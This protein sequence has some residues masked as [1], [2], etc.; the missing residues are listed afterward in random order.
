MSLRELAPVLTE[1][2]RDVGVDRRL[3][4]QCAQ[5]VKL[6]RRVRDVVVAAD[7]MRDSI[8]PVVE[9][10]S[11]VVRRAAVRA[12]QNEILELLV[13]EL[14]AV[15]DRVVPAGRAFVG[16]A[17]ADRALVLVGRSLGDEP[18]RLLLGAL[19]AVELERRLLVPVDAEPAKRTLDLGN[20]LG[21]L[22]ARVGVLDPQQALAP[23][24][25]REE[26]VEEEGA[27]SPDVEKARGGRCHANADAHA[28]LA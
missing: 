13:R 16:Y 17:D 11:E 27:H 19:E 28:A 1:D 21:D 26:P 9:G 5:D 20:R 3:G 23:A 2:A 25:T 12:E 6:L 7:H 4:A 18:R 15:L 24:P 14:D 8:E 22:P 10:R